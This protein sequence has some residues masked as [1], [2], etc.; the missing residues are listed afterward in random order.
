MLNIGIIGLGDISSIHIQAI[1]QNPKAQLVAICDNNPLLNHSVKHSRFYTN[2]DDMLE[3]ESLDCVH[4]CLPHYLH[5]YA[6]KKCVEKGVHVLQEKPLALNTQEGRELVALEQRYPNVK[7]GVCFQNRYNDTLIELKKI[8]ESG[9]Y[10]RPIG[11]KGVVTWYRPESY[12]ISK[13]WR[14]VMKTAGGGVMIN[15]SIHTLDLMQYLC[16]DIISIKGSITQLLDY[17]VEVEDTAS[18]QIKFEKGTHGLYF[19]TNAGIGNSSVELQVIFKNE[20]F[21]IKDNILTR[22]NNQGDKIPILED[23]K[24]TGTKSYYGPSHAK[25]INHF[26]HCILTDSSHYIHAKDALTSI[27]MVD[28]IAQSSQLEQSL[29]FVI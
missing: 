17:N 13:P 21:T 7:I 12:Y 2:I 25:L 6:T 20:K 18:A 4:V 5:A 9:I 16:G 10:G 27:A 24:A 22:L 23:I 28:T 15:Q 29:P 26:Y 8:V 1:N 19:A 3:A 11:I 14:G